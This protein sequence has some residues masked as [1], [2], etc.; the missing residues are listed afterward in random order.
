MWIID[1][2][3]ENSTTAQGTL[4]EINHH[5]TQRGK[6]KVN[7]ILCRMKSYQRT[8]LE[9]IQ[10]IFDQVRPVVSHLEVSLPNKPPTPNNIDE[11][12]KG[13]LIQL[14]KEALFVQYDK[15]KNVSLILY[16]TPIKSLPEVK[17]FL[18]SL[19][20]TSIKEG[21]FSDA[22]KLVS[23]HCPNGIYHIQGIDFDQSYSPVAHA[24]SFRINIAIASMHI[25]TTRILD[26]SNAFKNKNITIHERVC[27]STPP[28]YLDW[29]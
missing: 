29:F 13:T 15:N 12:L 11:G 8:D 10:S 20:D 1:I 18:R 22:W 26:V 14:W 9:G 21:D 6:Y 5:Q 19:I 23:R 27:V 16:I 4:D 2:N 25:I 7:I 24:E 28:Y 17:K 3:G